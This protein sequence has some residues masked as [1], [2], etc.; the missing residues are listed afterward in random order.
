MPPCATTEAPVCSSTVLPSSSTR[1]RVKIEL[2]SVVAGLPLVPGVVSGVV[3]G[4]ISTLLLAPSVRAPAVA[5][6][7]CRL[8]RSSWPPTVPLRASNI[9]EPF[10]ATLVVA[11]IRPLWFTAIATS[12]VLP[13][14]V[15]ILPPARLATLP[16]PC[17]TSTSKPRSAGND[18]FTSEAYRRSAVGSLRYTWE[19]P[20]SAVCPPGVLIVPA[21]W[22]FLANRNT[23]PPFAVVIAAPGSTTTK[24]FS[25]VNSSGAPSYA[26]VASVLA[27]EFVSPLMKSLFPT[28]SVE[29]ISEPT[30]TCELRPNR[31]PLALIR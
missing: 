7:F 11:L 2:A 15:S 18:G 6:C 19:P 12:V 27:I 13:R 16:L 9:T 1:E 22:T 28:F 17:P 23:R 10:S 26:K 24:F 3:S 14:G 25:F 31:M 30:L 8:L 29:A 4:A 21:F 5:A 20:A